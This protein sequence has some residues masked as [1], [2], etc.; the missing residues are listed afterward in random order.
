MI[1]TSLDKVSIIREKINPKWRFEQPPRN[2]TSSRAEDII[3]G[4]LFVHDPP[5]VQAKGRLTDI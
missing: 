4:L 3:N 2:K 5:M 1:L